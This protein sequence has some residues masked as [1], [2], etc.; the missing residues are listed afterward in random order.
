MYLFQNTFTFPYLSPLH[1]SPHIL[2]CLLVGREQLKEEVGTQHNTLEL[3]EENMKNVEADELTHLV[4]LD[5]NNVLLRR[6]EEEEM[7][8]EARRHNQEEE[9]N[10]QRRRGGYWLDGNTASHHEK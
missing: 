7:F 3:E 9:K 2:G 1:K 8:E 6:S 5:L 10:R 4:K